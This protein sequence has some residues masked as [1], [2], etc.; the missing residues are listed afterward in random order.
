MSERE[1]FIAAVEIA[2]SADR[3]AYLDQACAG[4]AAL[5]QR[6][7]LLLRANADPDSFLDKPP[8]ATGQLDEPSDDGTEALLP[9]PDAVTETRGEP[10]TAGPESIISF[11]AP[12]RKQENLGRL[13][14][15]EILSVIG[16]GGMGV[17]LKAHDERLDR[18]VAVKILAPQYAANAAARRRFLR[19]AKAIAA[20]AHEHVVAVHYVSDDSD[21]HPYLVMQLIEGVSLQ[22]R[23]DKT[24]PLEL[25]QILRIGL[26]T[27]RGLAAAHAQGLVHRDIKPA[28]ILLENGVERVKITDFGL[29]RAV[30]D[31]SVTTSGVIA[32][33]PMFMS[34]EQAEGKPVDARSDLFSLGSVLYA[35]C[36][37]RPPFRATGTMAV[38]KRVIEDIPR[39][40]GEINNEIPDWLDAIIAK[41]HAKKPE[42][43][44]Q[45]AKEVADLL[46]QHLAHLQQ[47]SKVLM[48]AK[49]EPPPKRTPSRRSRRPLV[50]VPIALVLFGVIVTIVSFGPTIRLHLTNSG[51]L[52]VNDFHPEFEQFVVRPDDPSVFGGSSV[53]VKTHTPLRLA[54]GKYHIQAVGRNDETVTRWREEGGGLFSGYATQKEGKTV[55]V[56]LK[57]G[58]RVR[59]SIAGWER[60]PKPPEPLKL[61][62]DEMLLQGAWE[63]VSSVVAGKPVAEEEFKDGRL[64]FSGRSVTISSKG[65]SDTTSYVLDSTNIPKTISFAKSRAGADLGIF[66]NAN[67]NIRIG[68]FSVDEDTLTICCN[69]V[70]VPFPT[71]FES[72]AGSPFGLYVFKR[73]GKQKPSSDKDRLQG[74]WVIDSHMLWPGAFAGKNLSPEE[75]KQIKLVFTG[76]QVRFHMP[77]GKVEGGTFKLDPAAHPAA[78]IDVI[79]MND[80]KGLFGIYSLTGDNLV[81]CMTQDKERPTQ[82][83]A[84]AGTTQWMLTLLKVPPDEL[85]DKDRLQ[86]TWIGVS[87]ESSGQPIPEAQL[88]QVRIT[89]TDNR[90]QAEQ[91]NKPPDGGTFHLV[92]SAEPKQFDAVGDD[93]KKRYGIYRFV[94]DELHLCMGEDQNARPV[95]FRSDPQFPT[96]MFIVLRR[97]AAREPTDLEKLQGV[98]IVSEVEAKGQQMPPQIM[99]MHRMTLT[100][101]GQ[102]VN[103]KSERLLAPEQR[104]PQK[105]SEVITQL[106][107]LLTVN[108]QENPKQ[109]TIS[110]DAKEALLAGVYRFEGDKLRIC[111]TLNAKPEQIPREFATKPGQE[112]PQMMVL[113]RQPPG[114]PSDKDRLQG[115][116]LAVEVAGD[117]NALAKIPPG[118]RTLMTFDGD[119]AKLLVGLYDPTAQDWWKPPTVLEG[120]VSLDAT[121]EPRRLSLFTVGGQRENLI[122]I[123]RLD[124]DRLDLCFDCNPAKIDFPAEFKT[125]P[126]SPFKHMVLRRQRAAEPG[127]VQLFNG[128]DLTG[129][130][131]HPDQPGGWKVEGGVLVGRGPATSH[132]FS[133]RGD[134]GNFRLRVEARVN[135]EGDGGVNFRVPAIALPRLFG[136][137]P[138]GFKAY[139]NSNA[140]RVFNLTGGLW[141]ALGNEEGETQPL[142]PPPKPGEWFT[143]EVIAE[144]ATI[145][146][147]VNGETT[148][149]RTFPAADPAFLRGHLALQVRNPGSVI[150]F[151]KIEIKE[152]PSAFIHGQTVGGWGEV[153]DPNRDCQF[154]G[155]ANE[156][157]ITVPGGHHNLHPAAP[158]QNL[159]APR[160]LQK[161]NGD[162]D[163]QVRVLPFNRPKPNTAATGKNSY[164]GAGLVLWQDSNNFVRFF[165]AANGESGMLVASVEVFKDG[166][167]VAWGDEEIPDEATHLRIERHGDRCRFLYGPDGQK[168]TE[169]PNIFEHLTSGPLEVGIAAANSTTAT[170]AAEFRKLEIKGLAAEEPGW[171][172]LFN[173]KD[174]TGWN[175]HHPKSWVIN[176]DILTCSGHPNGALWTEK[177]YENYILRLD[178][179][180]L[181]SPPQAFVERKVDFHFHSTPVQDKNKSPMVYEVSIGLDGKFQ[182]LPMYRAKGMEFKANGPKIITGQWNQLEIRCVADA[183]EV[184]LNGKSLGKITGCAPQKGQI[185]LHSDGY[186][187][188]VN[189]RKIEIK[190]LPPVDRSIAGEWDSQFG[191]VTLKHDPLQGDKQVTVTG[192]YKGPTSFGPIHGGVYD[193]AKRTVLISYVDEAVNTRGSSELYLIFD[194]KAMAGTWSNENGSAGPW[195][196]RRKGL[197]KPDPATWNVTGDWESVHGR[198][199][200]IQGELV[201]GLYEVKGV[202]TPKPGCQHKFKAAV[203][204]PT[205]GILMMEL[206][207]GN[208]VTSHQLLLSPDGKELI[209]VWA[210][211]AGQHGLTTMTREAK[212]A[213]AAAPPTKTETDL[214]RLQGTW[215]AVMLADNGQKLDKVPPEISFTFT[216]DDN[217]ATGHIVGKEPLGQKTVLEEKFKGKLLLEEAK[218]PKQITIFGFSGKSSPLRGIYRLESDRLE[219]CADT[220]PLP[221]D[222]RPEYPKDFKTAPGSPLRH[223]VLERVVAA[224]APPSAPAVIITGKPSLRTTI[225]N[226]GVVSLAFNA[227]GSALISGGNDLRFY[228]VAAGNLLQ[229]EKFDKDD[230][231]TALS[232][233]KDSKTL[234]V[235]GKQT[236]YIF[237]LPNR[238][239]PLESKSGYVFSAALSPDGKTLAYVSD[240]LFFLDRTTGKTEP[241][242]EHK[243]LTLKYTPDGRNLI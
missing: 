243:Y 150:E 100:V 90:I 23:L 56:E 55:T 87:G 43:R 208:D 234:A 136:T 36:T 114:E 126:G 30:D 62:D 58:E 82:F 146:I 17:V 135:D 144:R 2:D 165:R 200:L 102:A 76:G 220:S 124:G 39:P 235:I 109:I 7:E 15:Y 71:R 199:T 91:P 48:P 42:D 242:C 50:V 188:T 169:I 88:K 105:D 174:L 54:P 110:T 140:P 119:K 168:W 123:Y 145:T 63:M 92:P 74:T 73:E 24:G 215:K 97:A 186:G 159:S 104:T 34:P 22:E 236:A 18:V 25:K 129:W 161:V 225:D 238:K 101:R 227:D 172:Q 60:V 121:K 59:L 137:F 196:L 49:V 64:A 80:Q 93:Q 133:E 154:A 16:Q 68:I 189:Y 108:P 128:K 155:T 86:G 213:P 216:F 112:W 47:P 160:V 116:W 127:W 214:Q 142:K 44:F 178:F 177:P 52:T 37:G 9:T 147:K 240:R 33:T 13:G 233:T 113:K 111:Y 170:H 11:L 152:L 202:L 237:D 98:W 241:A 211:G 99:N 207:Q 176:G 156:L 212:T 167:A 57:R 166:K 45:S 162:F 204:E 181:G 130:K 46:E 70:D 201:K 187:T 153:V 224:A 53:V 195:A 120:V 67:V 217:N 51:Q 79:D 41:L 139:L 197:P 85:A 65:M 180:V 3:V 228:D 149:A 132:L 26:Q 4:D 95:E 221:P 117:G 203:F 27:A 209:G 75:L 184:L 131:T 222:A 158:F 20:V 183:L 32:G 81:I 12:P 38:M 230:G 190:E 191:V 118:A 239:I 164:V 229:Q 232:L 77:G 157:T 14:H 84:K 10:A 122:G 107:G 83:M 35:L 6:V 185:A 125:K 134:Y 40:V 115:T 1:I 21:P 72:P 31:A 69:A 182:I 28:N 148:A 106:E 96:R 193:P 103:F 78:E 226:K 19:E 219:I 8:L 66:R 231:V 29:A 138:E 205:L 206:T 163:T 61:S 5:R 141:R 175:V 89:F 210:T 173:G 151:R 192:S 94:G 179:Q 223:W 171:V 198:F 194:G 218:N 143:L